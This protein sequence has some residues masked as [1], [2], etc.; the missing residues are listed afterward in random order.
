MATE[1]NNLATLR[2]ALEQIAVGKPINGNPFPGEYARQ[3]A[4]R[5]LVECDMSWSTRAEAMVT[6]PHEG[7]IA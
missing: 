7:K 1:S 5:A 2:R 3:I 4:R 6:I